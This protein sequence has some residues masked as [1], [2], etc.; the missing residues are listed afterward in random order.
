MVVYLK[1]KMIIDNS[2]Y[3][4]ITATV[5]LYASGNT[6]AEAGITLWIIPLLN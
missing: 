2:L 3:E 1:L 4:L 5:K 6:S